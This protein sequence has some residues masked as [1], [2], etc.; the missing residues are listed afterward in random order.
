MA[1]D[2]DFTNANDGGLQ[3]KVRCGMVKIAMDIVGEAVGANGARH[4]KR[5]NLGVLVLRDGGLEQLERFM[6]ACCSGGG[7]TASSTD[8]D[9][10]NRLSAIWDDLA[11]VK[12]QEI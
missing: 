1:Y 7:L 5:H 6:F 10:N 9:I 8:T 12:I 4:E 2:T 11:G 3:Q